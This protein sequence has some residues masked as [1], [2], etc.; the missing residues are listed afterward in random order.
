[1]NTV[2]DDIK[3]VIK[4]HEQEMD[5]IDARRRSAF[6]TARGVFSDDAPTPSIMVM[7]WKGKVCQIK[8]ADAVCKLPKE[9]ITDLFNGVSINACEAWLTNYQ[10]LCAGA[11]AG[12][13]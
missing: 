13:G 9:D 7:V 11:G 12:S 6:E 8:I 3:A 5:S 4:E 10:A 1:M 2:Y